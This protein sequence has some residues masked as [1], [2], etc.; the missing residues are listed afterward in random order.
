L[1][2]RILGVTA[3]LVLFSVPAH[4]QVFGQYVGAR[5][6]AMNERLFGGYLHFGGDAIG[7]VAQLRLS[8][9]PGLDFGFQGGLTNYDESA[10]DVTTV[11]LGADVRFLA[12]TADAVNPVDVSVGGAL[13]LESGDDL[14]ILTI[15]PSV[16]ASRTFAMGPNVSITPYA[17]L[18]LAF[19]TIDA[20]E[21]DDS[22]F[23]VPIRLGAD[24]MLAQGFRIT[25]ELQ[26]RLSDE[27]SED[28]QFAAGV[29]L[30]F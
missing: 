6:L 7:G 9:Q 17:S 12:M 27:F 15:A 25:G 24:W 21:F 13:G 1:I 19:S 16:A 14:N 5:P 18:L 11:R 23:S 30:P 3:A 28:T 20:G 2:R 22:D 10:G 26:L 4:A 8:F 29:N